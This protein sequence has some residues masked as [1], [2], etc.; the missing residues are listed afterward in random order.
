MCIRDSSFRWALARWQIRFDVFPCERLK[1][2]LHKLHVAVGAVKY[3]H[4]R[5]LLE[6][7]M[8]TTSLILYLRSTA[9]L[10]MLTVSYMGCK[11]WDVAY[12]SCLVGS[13]FSQW[14]RPVA[15]LQGVTHYGAS[16]KPAVFTKISTQATA[17]VLRMALCGADFRDFYSPRLCDHC[18]LRCVEQC[19]E[20]SVTSVRI[21]DRCSC[22]ESR[23][24]PFF[25]AA[26]RQLLSYVLNTGR[27][28]GMNRPRYSA[29]RTVHDAL[30]SFRL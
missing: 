28:V 19:S 8:L 4:M 18:S 24:M 2:F 7:A 29:L 14:E 13:L 23:E 22:G 16:Q 11:T 10:S 20:T 1:A 6:S 5:L 9:Q 26:V 25:S 27:P 12:W 17:A 15:S 3:F 21:C 30:R